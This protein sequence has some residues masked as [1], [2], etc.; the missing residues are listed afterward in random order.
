MEEAV[1]YRS[2][3]A[4][5]A[6]C[7]SDRSTAN[8]IDRFSAQPIR[9]V[10]VRP[11]WVRLVTCLEIPSKHGARPRV[12]W[13]AS[14]AAQIS[15]KVAC[16]TVV[17]VSSLEVNRPRIREPLY[18]RSRGCRQG[19]PRGLLCFVRRCRSVDEPHAAVRALSCRDDQMGEAVHRRRCICEIKSDVVTHAAQISILICHRPTAAHGRD[20]AARADVERPFCLIVRQARAK[21]GDTKHGQRA[22]RNGPD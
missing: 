14:R 6:R 8:L 15:D 1:V 12:A 16:H 4:K 5:S 7:R 21:T 3:P 22:R 11:Q 17:T 19:Y 20:T 13:A 10:A 2:L 9:P 18:C